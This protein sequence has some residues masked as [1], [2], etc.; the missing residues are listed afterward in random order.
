MVDQFTPQNVHF[1]PKLGARILQDFTGADVTTFDTA[2]FLTWL[3]SLENH[4]QNEQFIKDLI[5]GIIKASVKRQG[6]VEDLLLLWELVP[7]R[8]HRSSR[9]ACL[10]S[11]K[12]WGGGGRPES[13][14][15]GHGRGARTR[16][17]PRM[18]RAFAP[19]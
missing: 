3:N 10:I 16:S 11:T 7:M 13:R 19:A 1:L 8:R 2:H 18:T 15:R 6:A 5:A 14:A 9:S 4:D 17:V 12:L